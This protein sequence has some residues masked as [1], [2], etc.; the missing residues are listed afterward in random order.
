MTRCVIP[1]ATA[2]AIMRY[3]SKDSGVVSFDLKKVTPSK[4]VFKVDSNAVFL[5]VARSKI[6]FVK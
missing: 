1:F 4:V 6:C 5:F 3:K 2:S